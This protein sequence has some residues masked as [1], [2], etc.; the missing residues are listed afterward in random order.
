MLHLSPTSTLGQSLLGKSRTPGDSATTPSESSRRVSTG[1][2]GGGGGG[3][4]VGSGVKGAINV[5][6]INARPSSEKKHSISKLSVPQTTPHNTGHSHD[7][8]GDTHNDEE[9][10]GESSTAKNIQKSANVTPCKDVSVVTRGDG[11]VSRV[12]YS[13]T[14]GPTNNGDSTAN[15]VD[16]LND[17]NNS[18]MNCTDNTFN[19]TLNSLDSSRQLRG[20]NDNNSD[21]GGTEQHTHGD[22][23]PTPSPS[24]SPAKG[25]FTQFKVPPLTMHSPGH[26]SKGDSD[27]NY[28]GILYKK[29]STGV[30]LSRSQLNTKIKLPC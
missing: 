9:D 30:L 28:L 7:S 14:T 2:V 3:V 22:S 16:D 19:N 23:S 17:T 10:C 21:A 27:L 26:R 25:R 6:P 11:S 8:R 18:I 24:P 5:S 4:G 12:N 13:T 1:E 15:N 20:N 29:N